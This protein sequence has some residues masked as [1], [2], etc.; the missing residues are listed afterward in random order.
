[1]VVG[2]VAFCRNQGLSHRNKIPWR[3]PEDMRHFKRM[4]SGCVVVMGRKTYESIGHAL[5]N[6]VN[7]VL[8][9]TPHIRES[10]ENVYFVT[11]E[12]A[13]RLLDRFAFSHPNIFVIGG[14]EIYTLFYDRM[15]TMYVTFV[16]KSFDTDTTF[17]QITHAFRLSAHSENMYSETEQC[18][19]RFLKYERSYATQST[20]D[21]AYLA[22]SK[23]IIESSSEARSLRTNRT[24]VPTISL[25]G[26]H[27]DFDMS[28]SIPLLTT[29]R[30]AWKSCIEELLWFLRGDTNASKLQEKNVRIW[31]GNSSREFL[32]KVGLHNLEEGDCGANYSFQWRYYGQEYVDSKTEY[33]KHTV[34]DQI[35]NI[36]NLLK[37]NPTSRR[38]FMSAWNPCQLNKTVL[39]PCHVSC[40]FYVEDNNKLSCHMYQRSCDVFLGL[41]FNIFSYAVLTHILAKKCGMTPYKLHISFGDIHI[42]LNHVTQMKEQMTRQALTAPKLTLSEAVATKSIDELDISDFTLVGYFPHPVIKGEMAI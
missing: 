15:H 29:K 34:G 7:V 9:R 24:E 1:M 40:Q 27:L 8:T 5:P 28:E 36:I 37:T 21:D 2:I 12:Q 39:P 4:T 19:F 18:Y 10:N 14:R 6:R 32:D 35:T 17:P 16:D 26:E 42:Y 41:P 22:L 31:D 30:V 11:F 38:I 23:K 33:A 13:L 3:I 20:C 25:F